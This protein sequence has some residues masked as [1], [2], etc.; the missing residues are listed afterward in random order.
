M[1]IQGIMPLS[2][3]TQNRARY[4]RLRRDIGLIVVDL[5]FLSSV[6]DLSIQGSLQLIS[7]GRSAPTVKCVSCCGGDCHCTGSCCADSHVL[8]EEDKEP[9]ADSAG[10]A[11]S[12]T[13]ALTRQKDCDGGYVLPTVSGVSQFALPAGEGVRAAP[14]EHD[15]LRLIVWVKQASSFDASNTSPR[16]PPAD[17]FRSLEI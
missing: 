12:R 10:P 4:R 17:P 5:L 13:T 11:L 16:G 8:V 7:R 2:V 9:P 6:L 3:S 1:K 15:R 14:S